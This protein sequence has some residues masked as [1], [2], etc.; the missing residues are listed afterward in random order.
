M[1]GYTPLPNSLRSHWKLTFSLGRSHKHE[2]LENHASDYEALS[3]QRL[4]DFFNNEDFKSTSPL[5]WGRTN[6]S[7]ATQKMQTKL[8]DFDRVFNSNK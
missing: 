7:S 3:T 6:K 8:R 2:E 4:E 1:S 5:T